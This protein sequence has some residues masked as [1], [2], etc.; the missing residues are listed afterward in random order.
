MYTI[1]ILIII[2]IIIFICIK[3]GTP[4]KHIFYNDTVGIK[5]AVKKPELISS[6][7]SMNILKKQFNPFD[8]K[9]MF[10]KNDNENERNG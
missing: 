10:L 7:L 2:E 1:K 5:F 6:A 3:Y 9:R 8:Y 4:Q